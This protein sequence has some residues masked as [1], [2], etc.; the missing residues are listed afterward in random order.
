L[1]IVSHVICSI[2][3]KLCCIYL[4]VT[5]LLECGC[6]FLVAGIADDL[7]R[8]KCECVGAIRPLFPFLMDWFIPTAIYSVEIIALVAETSSQ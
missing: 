5:G 2:I 3:D 7:A 8:R 6:G 4:A 1:L